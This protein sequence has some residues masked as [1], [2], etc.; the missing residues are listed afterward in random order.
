MRRQFLKAAGAL[1]A[2]AALPCAGA[3]VA[4]AAEG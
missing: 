3:D 2:A 4:R 1:L